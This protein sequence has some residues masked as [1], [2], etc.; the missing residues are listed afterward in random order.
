[1]WADGKFPPLDRSNGYETSELPD[2]RKTPTTC[3]ALR[4]NQ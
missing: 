1:M 2:L 4:R 3:N